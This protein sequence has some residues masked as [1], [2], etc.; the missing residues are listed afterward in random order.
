MPFASRR[1]GGVAE[2]EASARRTSLQLRLV[3]AGEI[4]QRI[5]HLIVGQ[6]LGKSSATF[7]LFD[8]I[9]SFMFHLGHRPRCY[10]TAPTL[11]RPT[12]RLER[13]FLTLRLR[14]AA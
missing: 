3:S 1:S 10:A 11:N 4:L 9:D 7:D 6:G 5:A 14:N 2:H 13:E 12:L 8:Q